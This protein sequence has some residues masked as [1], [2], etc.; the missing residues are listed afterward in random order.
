MREKYYWLITGGWFVLR[1]KYCWL[2]ADK[3]NE[4][5]KPARVEQHRLAPVPLH[6]PRCDLGVHIQHHP[7]RG[8]RVRA[9]HL[10]LKAREGP[11][12]IKAK[13]DWGYQFYKEKQDKK[14]TQ[15]GVFTTHS[16]TLT[17]LD[18]ATKPAKEV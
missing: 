5:G 3:P 1:E 4:Q 6:V 14:S 15:I 17:L 12:L 18:H 8:A 13:I 9:R 7:R 2:V 16:K 10:F 11:T